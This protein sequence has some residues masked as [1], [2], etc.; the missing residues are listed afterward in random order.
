MRYYEIIGTI[1]EE[2]ETRKPKKAFVPAQFSLR[3]PR[4]PTAAAVDIFRSSGDAEP[5]VDQANSCGMH[6]KNGL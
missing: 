5:L 1:L 3:K 2:A 4:Y 6:V